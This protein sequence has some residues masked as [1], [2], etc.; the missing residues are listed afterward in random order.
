MKMDQ[1]AFYAVD[2]EHENKIK[3]AL[4][5]AEKEWKEDI[6]EATGQIRGE[7][8]LSNKA[9]LQFNYDLGMEVEIIRYLEGE[10]WHMDNPLFIRRDLFIS[11]VGI[12]LE[13]DEDFPKVDLKLVQEVWT[14]KHTSPYLNEIGRTYHYRIYEVNPG[15]YIKYI[16]RIEKKGN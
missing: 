5:L 3:A 2:Q 11:H 13:K 12:H 16:K 15:S 4:G 7:N 6:V 8:K 1:I 14:K 10:H 9:H